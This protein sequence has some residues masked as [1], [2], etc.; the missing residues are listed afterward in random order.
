M[1][2]RANRSEL[3]VEVNF[4]SVM[5]LVFRE[6][7]PYQRVRVG[8]LISDGTLVRA[9]GNQNGVLPR[10]SVRRR[11]D[12]VSIEGDLPSVLGIDLLPS[13]AGLLLAIRGDGALL[14]RELEQRTSGW[15]AAGCPAG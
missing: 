11:H 12:G 5:Q 7:E 1:V 14:V 10:A 3:E 8:V 9:G 15:K 13:S 6:I 2:G 4:R